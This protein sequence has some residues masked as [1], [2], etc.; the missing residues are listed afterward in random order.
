MKSF[1]PLLFLCLLFAAGRESIGQT[2]HDSLCRVIAETSHSITAPV[3]S[4]D[5]RWL[6]FRKRGWEPARKKKDL[7]NDTI[8]LFDLRDPENF[9][10]A[11]YR[12]NVWEMAFAGNTHLLLSNNLQ[13]ELL[14]LKEQTSRYFTGVQ[15]MQV[16]N[17][18]SQFVLHYNKEEKGRL[19]LRSTDGTLLNAMDHVSRFY[20]AENGDVFAVAGSKEHVS[21]VFLV[22]DRTQEKVYSSAHEILSLDIDP[23]RQ[24]IMIHEQNAEGNFQDILYL[25][26]KTKAVFPL[27]EVLPIAFQRVLTEVIMEGDVYFM[28]LSVQKEKQNKA[29]AEIWY[30]N[31][32]RLEE[33]FYSSPD[34]LTYVWEPRNHFIRQVGNDHLTTVINTGND[35]YFLCFD[36]CGLQD[37]TTERTR[38]QVSVYD[39][40]ADRYALLDTIA[41]ELY[42]SGDGCYGLSPR[43][44]GWRLYHFPLE[45]KKFI[46]GK[47]PGT[48]WFTAVGESVLFEGKEALWQYCLKTGVLSRA[49]DFGGYQVRII[50]GEAGGIAARKGSF[51]RHSVNLAQPLVI[52]LYDPD[53]NRT[54]YSL[55]RKGKTEVILPPTTKR[56]KS[57]S[58][59]PSFTCFSWLEED[60]NLPPRLVYKETGKQGRVLYQS[61]PQDTAVLSLRQEIISYTNSDSIPLKGVLYY[62]PGYD[63]SR[64]YP[65]VV[66]IYEKQNH[67]ANRYP[68]PSYYESL[69]FN[70][71]LFLENGYF[72]YLPDIL[73]QGK[74]GP[75]MDALDCVNH[76]LDALTRN[77][78]I[79]QWRIGLIGHSFGGYETDFIATRSDRF[80]AYVSGSGHSDLI[81]AC[82][83]FNYNF[84]F[85]DHVRIEANNYKLGKPFS[86]D[87]ALYFKNNPLYHAEKVNAPVLL[88]SGLEDKNVTS[89]HTMAFYNALRRNNKEVIALFY[90]G[91]GHGLQQKPAQ[92]DLTS[93]ILDWFNYFLKGEETATGWIEKGINREDAP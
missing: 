83:A 19:E 43:D 33:K 59:N 7:D 55:W 72:V 27:K 10:I 47:G 30:G 88:W 40:A 57:L 45:S 91:E 79:D 86:T 80:A 61:N 44:G 64:K 84:R 58:Y 77:P 50:N 18:K 48:P 73:I 49:A 13:M 92:F 36:P 66:H 15:R 60:Y 38:L 52:E 4:D 81:W 51:A 93:R 90:K 1:Y 75:G 34:M 71:R 28:K 42:L 31:D 78:L 63:P 12:H 14:D 56:I 70:I 11:L 23:S 87:K 82:H 68:Y 74:E 76:A 17:N 8:L 69:G 89:D 53:K 3:L 16:L 54:G 25:D 67:L 65:M 35:R 26:L 6:I 32:N 39:R 41:P 29:V 24:G 85:P 20:V 46:Q 37:Y 62:P 2:R 21:D 5:G 22:R 9:R